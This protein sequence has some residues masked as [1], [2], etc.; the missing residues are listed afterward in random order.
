MQKVHPWTPKKKPMETK[1][2]PKCSLL[3]KRCDFKYCPDCG[4]RLDGL[5]PAAGYAEPPMKVSDA[6]PEM[7]LAMDAMWGAINA[8]E[9]VLETLIDC[10]DGRLLTMRGA[11]RKAAGHLEPLMRH[12]AM[13]EGRR[14]PD[15]ATTDS[16]L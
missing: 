6:L 3:M 8:A 7:L 12:T 5:C 11:L 15:S 9:E 1:S 13:D 4:A 2:C 16:T 10:N 14:T